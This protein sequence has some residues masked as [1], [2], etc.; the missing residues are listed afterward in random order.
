MLETN[1]VGKTMTKTGHE[2]A[3]RGSKT[4][5]RGTKNLLIIYDNSL[6]PWPWLY[7]MFSEHGLFFPLVLKDFE[8]P[9]AQKSRDSSCGLF[10]CPM[11]WKY[12][13]KMIVRLCD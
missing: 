3:S 1:V 8:L 5:S 4:R 10:W 7:Y 12:L 9:S 6:H 13:I 2:I 11:K